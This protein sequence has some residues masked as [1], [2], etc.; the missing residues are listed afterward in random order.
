MGKSVRGSSTVSRYWPAESPE[1]KQ[2]APHRATPPKPT[3]ERRSSSM[4]NS[5]SWV[6]DQD[7]SLLWDV[8]SSARA[9]LWFWLR[10]DKNDGQP[11]EPWRDKRKRVF[12]MSVLFS[13]A[14]ERYRNMCDLSTVCKGI[15]TDAFLQNVL[16]L[17]NSVKRPS[18]ALSRC[19][20]EEK[21]QML[22]FA[23]IFLIKYYE[24]LTCFYAVG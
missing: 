7:E 21:M 4:R 20:L 11:R 3:A 16:N 15:K 23:C 6:S 24:N 2:R 19:F 17:N 8:T 18:I 12:E 22:W 1:H 5:D 14:R 9:E 10:K 13:S